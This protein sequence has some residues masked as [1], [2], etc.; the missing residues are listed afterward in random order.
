MSNNAAPLGQLK[1]VGKI[2]LWF[3]FVAAAGLLAL[4]FIVDDSGSTYLDA[5]QSMS[6]TRKNLPWMML[7]GGLFLVT[8]TGVTT[9]L[10][11]LYSSFRVAGPIF[12]FTAN[13]EQ[14]LKAGEVPLV[15]VR[16][17]DCL[18][19]ES[20]TLQITVKELYGYYQGLEAQLDEAIETLDRP[21]TNE[22]QL[23][24]ILQSLVKAANKATVDED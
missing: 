5:V 23:H 12:R 9:W 19:D 18:Q 17:D 20:Q 1:I 6:I 2:S 14:G 13:L 11:T 8:G 21:G 7:V 22:E 10:I 3:S 4:F 24:K 16:H 15:K